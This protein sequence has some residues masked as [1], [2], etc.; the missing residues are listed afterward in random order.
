VLSGFL[1]QGMGT[2]ESTIF[3]HFNPVSIISFV[4]L[5]GIV[6]SF[7]FRAGQC[8]PYSHPSHP[9]WAKKKLGPSFYEKF[10]YQI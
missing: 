5:S 6:P 7:A 3:F 2:T 9:P 4:F 10:T 1:M 8:N